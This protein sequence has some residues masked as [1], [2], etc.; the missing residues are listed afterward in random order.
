M[1]EGVEGVGW[2]PLLVCSPMKF[3][4]LFPILLPYLESLFVPVYCCLSRKE[5]NHNELF[6]Q[7]D[8]N[9][10]IIKQLRAQAV[11]SGLRLI[12]VLHEC[13]NLQESPLEGK[14][15]GLLRSPSE[16][17]NS[18]PFPGWL[19]SIYAEFKSV[20]RVGGY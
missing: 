2:P 14:S 3:G 1:G 5:K 7:H 17:D 4:C 16:W 6:L 9:V 11:V 12:C 13:Y 20:K 8:D 10:C 15:Y 19:I 18:A